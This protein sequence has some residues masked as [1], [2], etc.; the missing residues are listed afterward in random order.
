MIRKEKNMTPGARR[1]NKWAWEAVEANGGPAVVQEWA[2]VLGE[3]GTSLL[4]WIQ[5]NCSAKSLERL[6]SRL[7]LAIMKTLPSLTSAM[8]QLKR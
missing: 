6:D 2:K 1:R 4:T 3:V 8:V 7:V 5:R